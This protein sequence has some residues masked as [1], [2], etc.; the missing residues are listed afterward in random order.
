MCGS[1]QLKSICKYCP[2]A[3][4]AQCPSEMVKKVTTNFFAV[5]WCLLTRSFSPQYG[6][7]NYSPLDDPHT[8]GL[9]V[10]CQAQCPH[11]K[12]VIENYGSTNSFG[13]PHTVHLRA[14]VE[15]A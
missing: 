8:G 9:F 15:E 11:E 1:Q 14:L 10:C 12:G 6:H 4:C 5:A 2:V 3:I 13:R 7:V